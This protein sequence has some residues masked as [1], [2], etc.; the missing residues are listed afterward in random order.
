MKPYSISI[1]PQS[2]IGQEHES[3]DYADAFAIKVPRQYA[4]PPSEIVLLFF[5]SFPRWAQVLLVIRESLGR[6]IGLKTA[7]G[8]DVAQQMKDFKGK[9]GQSIA[10]FHVKQASDT[11]ILT[12]EN[13]KHLDFS[14]SFFGEETEEAFEITL[15]T[16]V[17][18][19]GWLGKLYFLPV[20]PIHRLL[21]PAMLRKMAKKLIK[22]QAQL[23]S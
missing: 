21:V 10:L 17:V 15:A 20:K 18:F 23:A 2:L 22:K 16:T 1:N 13:D 7:K 5:H 11:E 3:V 6:L 19:N 9:P 12:G 4:I 14:L 8:L